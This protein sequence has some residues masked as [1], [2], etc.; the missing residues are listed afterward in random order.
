MI[1]EGNLERIL[2][3]NKEEA[4]ESGVTYRHPTHKKRFFVTTDEEETIVKRWK[5][6]GSHKKVAESMQ[7][8]PFPAVKK[9]INYFKPERT[10]GTVAT[11]NHL[12]KQDKKRNSGI[13]E[14]L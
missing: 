6:L 2:E 11:R 8:I 5:K 10:R 14:Y 3:I 1:N 7:S 13:E 9:I 4:G 12:N